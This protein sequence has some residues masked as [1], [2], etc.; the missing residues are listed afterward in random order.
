MILYLA[1]R[2][3]LASPNFVPESKLILKLVIMMKV[4]KR[5]GDEIGLTER[6]E[7]V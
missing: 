3:L 1:K 6:V 2:L 5:K 7:R 4:K